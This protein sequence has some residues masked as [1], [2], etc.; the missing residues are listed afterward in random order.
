M[1]VWYICQSYSSIEVRSDYEYR[2]VVMWAV[3]K[4]DNEYLVRGKNGLSPKTKIYYESTSEEKCEEWIAAH[5]TWIDENYG[6]QDW[7]TDDVEA[8]ILRV[9]AI[10]DFVK[11]FLSRVH[12]AA[13]E[14][15]DD[16][17]GI[18]Y[19]EKTIKEM[20]IELADKE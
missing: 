15:N 19:L 7:I 8:N 2:K 6:E 11:E 16:T 4:P 14:Y 13:K 3:I 18:E 20:G 12:K 10:E 5:S 1:K 17:F 9:A